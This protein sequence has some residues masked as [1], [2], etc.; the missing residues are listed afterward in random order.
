[1]ELETAYAVHLRLFGE[2]VVDFL[3]VIIKLVV[4]LSRYGNSFIEYF[5]LFLFICLKANGPKGLFHYSVVT[6]NMYRV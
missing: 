4:R 5:V 3:L 6:A 1:M 2:C